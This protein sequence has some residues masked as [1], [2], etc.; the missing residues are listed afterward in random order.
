M[1]DY[2]KF[3]KVPQI[4]EMS[5]KATELGLQAIDYNETLFKETLK[6]FNNATDKFFY[7]Y[8]VNM[9]DAVSK[10]TEYAKEAV[11]QAGLFGKVLPSTK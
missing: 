7:T 9:A 4:D 3:L 6:F 2:S 11:T 5:A 8:T 10:G 1:I